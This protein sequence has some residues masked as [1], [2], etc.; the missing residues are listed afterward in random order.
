MLWRVVALAVVLC[1]FGGCGGSPSNPLEKLQRE[2]DLFPQYAVILADMREDGWG[3]F[4]NYHHLYR[5]VYMENNSKESTPIL[6]VS[7]SLY[8]KYQPCLGMTILSRDKDGV[9]SDVPQPPAY[10]FVGDPRLGQW[11]TD[12][13]GQQVWQWIG[14]YLILS[15]IL[16]MVDGRHRIRYHDW[17]EYRT[18]ME[19]RKPYF[20]PRDAAGKTTYGTG[21]M[22]TEKKFPSFFERQ[23][24]RM[25]AQKANF[26][27]RVAENMGRTKVST[28]R[29]RTT[30]GSFGGRSGGK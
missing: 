21:G 3:F 23:R 26:G 19:R 11:K 6:P 7:K 24:A 8:Q 20:G 14:S 16:D 4:A 25:A 13:S 18:S 1:S 22:W 27:Q 9:V 12:E 28:F 15:S 29:T 2:L 5:I 30:G 10:Q 17:S